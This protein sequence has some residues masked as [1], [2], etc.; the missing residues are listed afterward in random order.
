MRRDAA[1]YAIFSA[2]FDHAT[3]TT[4]SVH[5]GRYDTHTGQA[6]TRTDGGSLLHPLQ[7]VSATVTGGFGALVVDANAIHG[8]F[9]TLQY[10][11]TTTIVCTNGNGNQQFTSGC[12]TWC[13][14]LGSTKDAQTLFDPTGRNNFDFA[15]DYQH[16]VRMPKRAFGARFRYSLPPLNITI[17]NDDGARPGDGDD[18]GDSESLRVVYSL[19]FIPCPNHGLDKR[20][21]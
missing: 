16:G 11:I 15:S 12:G 8:S 21:C 9:P 17:H 4:A 7:A 3:I 14:V 13:F 20:H 1:G 6:C 5:L 18:S 19:R 2:G 10:P